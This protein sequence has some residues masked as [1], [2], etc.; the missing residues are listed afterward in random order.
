M[1][2]LDP[3][4]LDWE[5]EQGLLPAVVQDA[6]TGA[7]LMLGYMDRAALTRTLEAR[8]V[9]FFSR[10]RQ[11]LWEKGETSGNALDL[12]EIRADCDRDALL[13]RALPRGPVCHL[14]T[15]TCFGASPPVPGASLAF[16]TALEGVIEARLRERPEGSYTAKLA[17]E[18]T[19]RVA[20]KFGEEALELVLAGAGEDDERVVSEGADALFHLLLL[21]KQRGLS[22]ARIVSALEARHRGA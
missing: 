9:V 15:E 5:K 13:V 10:S 8:R 11:R 2:G 17:A 20:Q 18:G 22:L 14:G 12:V 19:P 6:R 4:T 21:L 1:T 7:V 3:E 16:L